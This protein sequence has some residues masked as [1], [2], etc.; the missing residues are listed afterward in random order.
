VNQRGDKVIEVRPLHLRFYCSSKEN[1][2]PGRFS[3]GDTVGKMKR[4]M[5]QKMGI[6]EHKTWKM[7]DY[8]HMKHYK[9]LSD[10]KQTLFVAL[11]VD[12]QP[13]LFEHF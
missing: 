4:V 10:M 1:C 12:D 7:W 2:I 6:D 3:R 5:C 9:I 11:L 8:Y 13:I